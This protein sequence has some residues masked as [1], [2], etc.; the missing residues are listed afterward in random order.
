MVVGVA[1]L[2]AFLMYEAQFSGTIRWFLGSLIIAGVAVFAWF[3]VARATSEPPLLVPAVGLSRL[4]TGEL[5]SL[6]AA[7]RRANAGLPYSQVAVSTRVREAFAER[8]CLANALSPERIRRLEQDADGLRAVVHDPV[9]EDFLH[10]RS[11]DYDERYRWVRESRDHG[12]FES[13]LERVLEHMET[14]R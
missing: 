13:A 9:L 2:L 10:L 12:G 11:T 14:W 1:V 5:T 7:V 8:I 4:R 3:A 6:G